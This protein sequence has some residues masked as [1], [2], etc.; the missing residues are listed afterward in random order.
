MNHQLDYNVVPY[1][2]NNKVFTLEYNKKIQIEVCYN[3]LVPRILSLSWTNTPSPTKYVP[4]RELL[5]DDW[6]SLGFTPSFCSKSKML[7][8]NTLFFY[9]NT[10][11]DIDWAS[12]NYNMI[13]PQNNPSL[14]YIPTPISNPTDG[15]NGQVLGSMQLSLES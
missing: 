11:L 1:T 6:G 4:K 14:L 3:F 8:F 10:C 13:P 12:L 7:E 2:Y 5:E 9:P 15:Y